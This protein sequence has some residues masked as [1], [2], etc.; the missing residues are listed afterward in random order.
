MSEKL[1][2]QSIQSWMAKRSGWTVKEGALVKEWRFKSF[3]DSIVFVNR[4]ASLADESNQQ[5][6]ITIRGGHVRIALS[7]PR[8]GGI[9]KK[10]LELAQGIDFATSAR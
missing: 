3:R 7:T 6:E 4:I 1:N 8:S 2:Q 10:D 5:P 9:G